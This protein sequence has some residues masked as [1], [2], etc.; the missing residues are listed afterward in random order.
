V[1][2]HQVNGYFSAYRSSSKWPQ[3]GFEAVFSLAGGSSRHQTKALKALKE[4]V[5]LNSKTS[6]SD[7]AHYE[8]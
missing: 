3:V 4:S 6:T 7:I 1:N 8:K 5:F 2:P